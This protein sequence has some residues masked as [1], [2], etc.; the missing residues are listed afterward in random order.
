LV[1]ALKEP[2]S[3]GI[4]T[5]ALLCLAYGLA[6]LGILRLPRLQLRRQVPLT[7]TT[8][9]HP[10]VTLAL[11]GMSLGTGVSTYVVTGAVYVVTAAVVIARPA[12]YGALAFALFGF[13]RA[14]VVCGA[15]ALVRSAPDDLEAGLMTL[16]GLES[17]VHTMC[18]S[19]M[20]LVG[21]Y[22]LAAWVLW[23]A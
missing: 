3:S 21:G 2:G 11:F 20:M 5:L 15:T 19:L 6:E 22:W 4:L 23:P 13:A 12:I 8:R 10:Y 16:I 18:G 17:R 7:W 1:G 9:F 14:V